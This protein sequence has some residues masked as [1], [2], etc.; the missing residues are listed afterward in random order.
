MYAQL[1][2]V[3]SYYQRIHV[4]LTYSLDLRLEGK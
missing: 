2:L 1:A 3:L 4:V